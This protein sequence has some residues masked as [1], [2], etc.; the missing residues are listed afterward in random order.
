MLTAYSVTFIVEIKVNIYIYE[1]TRINSSLI[2][3]L[4]INA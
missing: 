2:S 3:Y 4:M 1:Y